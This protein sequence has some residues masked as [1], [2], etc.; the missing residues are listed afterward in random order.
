MAIVYNYLIND[1]GVILTDD[2]G[3]WLYVSIIDANEGKNLS[4]WNEVAKGKTSWV[5]RD[6][7]THV[8]SRT[9]RTR[10]T[11]QGD[12]R[13]TK[14]GTTRITSKVRYAKKNPTIWV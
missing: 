4:A 6:G 12:T 7:F 8:T 2:G 9:P 11:K 10:I 3:E 13:V 14:Q 1:D 5:H